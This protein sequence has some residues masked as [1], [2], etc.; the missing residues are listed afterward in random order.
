MFLNPSHSFEFV[1][2]ASFDAEDSQELIDS[3]RLLREKD[4]QFQKALDKRSSF[5]LFETCL[6]FVEKLKE[7]PDWV[8]AL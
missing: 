3:I 6:Y 5:S 7:F 2:Q 8:F 1:E 4:S